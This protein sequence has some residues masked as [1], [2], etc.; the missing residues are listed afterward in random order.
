MSVAVPLMFCGPLAVTVTG[1]G[2]D[3]TP[4]RAS[5]HVKVTVA[6]VAG[7]TPCAFGGGFTVAEMVGGVVSILSVMDALAV[8]PAASVTVPENTWF[9]PSVLTGID[10]GH[11][12]NTVP[13]SEQVKLT[14]TL[15]LFQPA[16]LELGVMTGVIVGGVRS[17]LTATLAV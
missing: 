16:A 4:E 1:E 6:L 9:A 10:A 13:A 8:L 2:Q 11:V 17:I 5:E 15:L 7:T 14:T 3:K 12:A